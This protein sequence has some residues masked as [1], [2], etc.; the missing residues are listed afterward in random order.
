MNIEKAMLKA[1]HDHSMIQEGDSILIGASGGKD[2]LALS[3]LLARLAA[4]MAA[5]TVARTADEATRG[6]PALKLGALK[7]VIGPEVVPGLHEKPED[8]LSRLYEDW[9]IPLIFFGIRGR[10]EAAAVQSALQVGSPAGFQ[11]ARQSELGAG[12]VVSGCYRCSSLR[13]EALAS[14]ARQEGYGSIALGHHIDDVLTTALMNLVIHGSG[15]VMEPCRSYEKFGLLLIRP[16]AYVP[17]ESIKRL[18]VRMGWDS[19]TCSCPAGTN[20]DRA[21]FR[22]RLEVLCGGKLSAKLKLLKGL[23]L[24]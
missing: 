4:R 23:G 17:E 20:G 18:A 21:E 8:R 5:R 7:V 3:W 2:S 22:R 10:I 11:S 9:G 1:I 6:R 14:Y 12:E 13:R 19:V 15:P 24:A 16:L